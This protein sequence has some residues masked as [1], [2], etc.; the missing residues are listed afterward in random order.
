MFPFVDAF[1]SV[2][3]DGGEENDKDFSPFVIFIKGHLS[4]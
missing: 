2:F 1:Y 3:V 4:T